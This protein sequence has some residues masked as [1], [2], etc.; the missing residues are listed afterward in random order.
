MLGSQASA[1]TCRANLVRRHNS[2]CGHT[3]ADEHNALLGNAQ[4]LDQILPDCGRHRNHLVRERAQCPIEEVS[5]PT[6]VYRVG[7]LFADDDRDATKTPSDSGQ[8]HPL[9][10]CP[11]NDMRSKPSDD[12]QAPPIALSVMDPPKNSNFMDAATSVPKS[13]G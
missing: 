12:S 13:G 11:M 10:D 7:C 2:R 1:P 9:K 5:A 6:A 3:V 4:L 8:C